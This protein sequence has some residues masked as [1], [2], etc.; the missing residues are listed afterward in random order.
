MYRDWKTVG[1]RC[2]GHAIMFKD[3]IQEKTCYSR[4]CMKSKD[5]MIIME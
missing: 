5:G 4:G 3:I 2:S 1:H